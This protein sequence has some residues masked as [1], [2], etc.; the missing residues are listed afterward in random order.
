MR[1]RL[2][3]VVLGA[4]LLL[5]VPGPRAQA[6]NDRIDANALRAAVEHAL[7][8]APRT[9][10]RFQSPQQAGVRLVDVD[11]RPIGASAQQVVIDLSQRTLTYDPAGH[12]EPLLDHVLAATAPLT[13]GAT[14][15]RYQFL[16]DGLPL[17]QFL[18]RITSQVPSSPRAIANGGRVLVSGGHGWYWE[19]YLGAWSLQR[20]RGR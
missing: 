12:V 20:D 15:V 6:P 17:D 18:T 3:A 5:L 4:S 19:S 10:E 9:V 2:A 7:A 13:A 14:D 1:H 11:V 16:V 8:V